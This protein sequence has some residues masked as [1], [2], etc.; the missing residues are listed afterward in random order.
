[1]PPLRPTFVL[2]GDSITQRGWAPGGWAARL[3]DTYGRR[4]DVLNRGYSGYNTAKCLHLLPAVFP[5]DAEPPL[6][7]TVF[8]GANDASLPDRSSA[9]HNVPVDAYATN[10]RSIVAHVR[11]TYAARPPAVV[12]ITPPPVDE[13][14][15]QRANHEKWGTPLDALP[16]RT[17]DVTA[18]YAAA[19]AAVAQELGCPVVDTFGEFQR[20]PQWRASHL[21]DGLHFA[22]AGDEATYTLLMDVIAKQLPHL[23][24]T[25]LPY[26]FPE[27]MS[28]DANDPVR[29]S[30]DRAVTCVWSHACASCCA[31]S[32]GQLQAQCAGGG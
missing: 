32:A 6:V 2:F 11:S 22:P 21:N 18:T 28:V 17:L 14:A 8:L 19:C 1:M 13:A 7:G 25:A 30:A 3:A 12:L 5:P 9:Q 15:R 24:Y 29:L 27:W 26:D 31:Y 16:E 23:V 10:L 4:V 20:D